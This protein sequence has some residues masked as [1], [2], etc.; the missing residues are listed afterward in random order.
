[1]YLYFCFIQGEEGA[2]KKLLFTTIG[3]FCYPKYNS[4]PGRSQG[5]APCGR[6]WKWITQINIPP[7][8][9]QV[10]EKKEKFL[11]RPGMIQSSCELYG[12]EP[13][14]FRSSVW[15][16]PNWAISA[17]DNFIYRN[18]NRTVNKFRILAVTYWLERAKC[19]RH[20]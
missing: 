15:R 10:T 2:G 20:S 19:Y 16:S 6:G 8:N 17:T 9:G 4:S 5:R 7:T 12:F 1:M 13:G 11:P 3:W 18:V 14:T